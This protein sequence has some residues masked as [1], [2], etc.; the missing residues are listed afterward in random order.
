MAFGPLDLIKKVQ[1][2]EPSDARS[3]ALKYEDPPETYVA[4]GA[5]I[6]IGSLAG[7]TAIR[8]GLHVKLAKFLD[9]DPPTAYSCQ[10]LTNTQHDPTGGCVTSD[11]S[12]GASAN[13]GAATADTAFSLVSAED[14]HG[15]V[16]PFGLGRVALLQADFDKGKDLVITGTADADPVTGKTP[17]SP[18]NPPPPG[19][20]AQ[21]GYDL[22]ALMPSHVDMRIF[23]RDLYD[24]FEKD[25]TH[26]NTYIQVDARLDKKLSAAL[27]LMDSTAVGETRDHHHIPAVALE[28]RNAPGLGSGAPDFSQPT[29]R[30]RA[31]ISAP[32]KKS[33]SDN[34]NNF[35]SSG[36]S[37]IGGSSGDLLKENGLG[38]AFCITTPAPDSKWL[39]AALNAQPTAAVAPARTVDAF[40]MQSGNAGVDLDGTP[41]QKID[42]GTT[43]ADIRGFANILNGTPGEPRTPAP[44]TAQVGTRLAPFDF[45]MELGLGF[46]LVGFYSEY[47]TSGDL[48]VGLDGSNITEMRPGAGSGSARLHS[49]GGPVEMHTDLQARSETND[50][51]TVLF[52]LIQIHLH[53]D[54]G[55]DFH[56]PL[57]IYDCDSIQPSLDSAVVAANGNHR[58]SIGLNGTDLTYNPPGIDFNPAYL[59]FKVGQI[60]MQGFNCVTSTQD[61]FAPPNVPAPPFKDT[62]SPQDG[63]LPDPLSL[64]GTK[65]P[66]TPSG[67][68]ADVVIPDP[69]DPNAPTIVTTCQPVVADT[70]HIRPGGLLRAGDAGTTVPVTVTGAD[71]KTATVDQPCDGNLSILANNVIVEKGGA[72]SVSATQT[73]R[74]PGTPSGNGGGAGHDEDGGSGGGSGHPGGLAYGY[75]DDDHGAVVPG[76]KGADGATVAG[77][78]GGG[79]M[80]INATDTIV[81][82]GA[83]RANGATPAS[84][85]G[86][87]GCVSGAGGGS[88][89]SIQLSANYMTSTASGAVEVLGG[90]G[91]GS[92]G[93]GGGGGSGGLLKADEVVDQFSPT[94]HVSGGHGGAGD[95]CSNGGNA[96]NGDN[97]GTELEAAGN[98]TLRNPNASHFYKDGFPTLDIVGIDEDADAETLVVCGR[99]APYG[100]PGGLRSKLL[101][102]PADAD[103][104]GDVQDMADGC[105]THEFANGPNVPA[106]PEYRL[107]NASMH[108]LLDAMDNPGEGYYG[109]TAY[110]SGE[111]HPEGRTSPLRVRP[112]RSHVLDGAGRRRLRVPA[113]DAVHHRAARRGEP[114]PHRRH[115]RSTV[116]ELHDRRGH[117][118]RRLLE[119][120]PRLPS[121]ADP[122]DPCDQGDADRCRGQ[123]VHR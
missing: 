40:V 24:A 59:L 51:F 37:G 70:L 73:L 5:R 113:A 97:E 67:T 34:A 103:D 88:G 123:R 87:N 58:Y 116:R 118:P 19:L 9:L 54:S 81:L 72:I 83:L 50:I 117:L 7:K 16:A 42:G 74:G 1:E 44:V 64:G 53:A 63:V 76:S 93:N 26:Q 90:D 99:F 78:A 102:P 23:Q 107:N 104:V 8:A 13:N 10:R 79:L 25:G 30:L 89:G 114:R 35:A 39:Q 45:G 11:P 55:G 69:T 18:E 3:A 41:A 95:N 60:I 28:L 65:P 14:K 80:S 21:N 98:V 82:A 47:R 17:Y 115:L 100:T 85:Q 20:T 4:D 61:T 57:N 71:G 52:G 77:G 105:M 111:D 32:Q 120:P 121:Q 31:Q 29:F 48:V 119:R 96:G 12:I 6:K 86:G 112:H 33:V 22:G 56:Y 27:R 91:G 106:R 94:L 122:G 38:G 49:T 75:P 110:V 62:V 46:G 68:Q 101:D 84:K 43:S 92:A 66:A 108:D 109:L 15:G 2:K 36:C